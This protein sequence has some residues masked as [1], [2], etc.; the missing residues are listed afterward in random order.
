MAG[1][2]FF[3]HHF[4]Q[5]L[6]RILLGN[7]DEVANPWHGQSFVAF[8]HNLDVVLNQHV[9]DGL[10]V[11]CEIKVLFGVQLEAFQSVIVQIA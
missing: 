3:V 4:T 6:L 7:G 8:G 11:V 9:T 1:D 10:P 2:E 5:L